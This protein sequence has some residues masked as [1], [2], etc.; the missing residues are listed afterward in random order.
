MQRSDPLKG[1]GS[2]RAPRLAP[3][4]RRQIGLLNAAICGLAGRVTGGRPPNVFT[5]LAR[6]RRLFRRWLWFAAALMPGGKLPRAETE[7]VILRVAHLAGCTYEWDHH[8]HLGRRAGVTD[9][10]VDALARAEAGTVGHVERWTARERA[11]LAAVDELHTTRDLTDEAWADLRRHLDEREA[12][13][14][15]LLAGHYEMLATTLNTLRVQPDRPR[16]AR[17]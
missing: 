12:I 6:H 5:T 1:V 16:R 2:G 9:A 14:V 13:E 8:R 7:L 11:L 3:G 17:G 10:D 4:G 15:L